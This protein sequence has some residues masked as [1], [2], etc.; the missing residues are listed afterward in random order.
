M[1]ARK[2]VVQARSFGSVLR[3]YRTAANLTQDE[4]ARRSGIS[5]EAISMLERGLRQAPRSSTIELLASG[6]TLEPAQ[7]RA[8]IAAARHRAPAAAAWPEDPVP[9]AEAEDAENADEP[10]PAPAPARAE[11]PAAPAPTA[12]PAILPWLG[13][14]L[15]GL[16]L[17]ALAVGT[18]L[19]VSGARVAGTALAVGGT[20]GAV[21]AAFEA[22]RPALRRRGERRPVADRL[23]R[24]ADDLAEHVRL[25]WR[26]AAVERRL[27][28]PV[29]IP[30]RWRLSDLPVAGP[31]ADAVGDGAELSRFTRLPGI[32]AVS[33]ASLGSDNLKD[34]LA[35]YGGLDSGRLLLVGEPGAGKTGAAIR[36]LLAALD[37][38]R[39]LPGSRRSGV[40]VPVL[41]SPRGWD[42]L[43]QPLATWLALRLADDYPFLRTGA[44][45]RDLPLQ[46]VRTGRL[47]VVLDGLDE[48]PRDL[49]ATALRAL[50]EQAAFRLVVLSR[51]RELVAA[52]A[53]SH[54]SGAAALEL[55]PVPAA[56]AA[57][58]LARCQPR[59][60]PGAW[61]RLLDGI[62][63]DHGSPVARALDS[64]LPVTLLRDTYGPG[65][66]VDE[67][68]DR[69]RFGCPATVADH[70]LDRVLP[71]AY[72]PRPGQPP[73]R[74]TVAQAR[75]W[76]GFIAHRMGLEPTAG[77]LAWWLLPRWRRAWPRA[78]VT[79]VAVVL[80]GAAAGGLAGGRA[81]ALAVAG[82]VGLAAALALLRE[83]GPP[84]RVG[85]PIWRR[86]LSRA[87]LAFGLAV[88]LVAGLAFGVAVGLTIGPALGLVVGLLVGAI[89]GLGGGLLFGLVDGLGHLTVDTASPIDPVTSWRRDRLYSIVL[90]AVFSLVG[91]ITSG[92][93]WVLTGWLDYD[94]AS[95]L[96]AGLLG[97][98]AIGVV[99]GLS[100]AF[101]GRLVAALVG[102][103]ASG[104]AGTIAF[105][106]ILG[107]AMASAAALASGLAD[108]LMFG[109][110]FGLGFGL[111]F[112]LADSAT[113]PAAL[114]FAQ[115][116]LAGLGPL[117]LLHFL[118][119]A[120][121]RQVLRVAGPV[122]QFRHA[123]LR[124]RLAREFERDEAAD[125]PAAAPGDTGGA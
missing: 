110:A 44:G 18:G 90:V 100:G 21:L 27:L 120:R 41:L 87:N 46:L 68:L 22:A 8:L 39:S 23:D 59:P 54:L 24:A 4:L 111:A 58:Y 118:E 56:D 20:L 51:S 57:D 75:R 89:V 91:G 104:V 86:V 77:D 96:A 19:P 10:A 95:E 37:H 64:P 70:L 78:A 108:G 13:L 109:V 7:R 12:L 43:G 105:G 28:N 48:L 2:A 98:L 1:A 3:D 106:L 119:D 72:A 15:L 101:E 26:Q 61:R 117:R 6:L 125:G 84:R 123:R 55:Q 81:G 92:L 38:R 9:S 62:R 85:R 122:Y 34:L 121:D 97:G 67:L 52:A 66:P 42:P 5:V 93:A 33:A 16:V 53:E 35:V 29:P 14:A 71:A 115:L 80:A 36:L 99:L 102:R 45:A 69:E 76:L 112:T 32:G 30:L 83:P 40:P 88:G 103:L 11:A 114:A 82:T 113:W 25:Q 94:V 60:A 17:L 124:E 116:G 47:A 65:D 50:D 73:P 79:V 49:R 31:V 74:Y 63:S 107:L